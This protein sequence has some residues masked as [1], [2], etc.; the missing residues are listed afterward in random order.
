MSYAPLTKKPEAVTPNESGPTR[1]NHFTARASSWNP[2]TP[3]A[4]SLQVAKLAHAEPQAEASKK[5][6]TESS[7]SAVT[8]AEALTGQEDSGLEPK[9]PPAETARLGL[10]LAG[11]A[12]SPLQREAG[13]VSAR[14]KMGAPNRH[15]VELKVHRERLKVRDVSAISGRGKTGALEQHLAE[16]KAHRERLSA[17]GHTAGVEAPPPAS[18]AFERRGQAGGELSGPSARVA[19]RLPM[20]HPAR[21]FSPIL[22]HVQTKLR[23]GTVDDPLEREADAVA[24]R[25]LNGSGRETVSSGVATDAVQRL[26]SARPSA[27][28]E[29][30]SSALSG[31]ERL[32]QSGGAPLA[33]VIREFY[34][35]R[36]GH[37]F[38]G[39]RVHTGPEAAVAADQLG[40]KA[41]T[42]G[43]DMVFGEGQYQ[44]GTGEGKRLIAHELAHVVQQAKA[45]PVIQRDV[46]SSRPVR[47]SGEFVV[48]RIAFAL[49]DRLGGTAGQ[50]RIKQVQRGDLLK[51][52]REVPG[53]S[54]LAYYVVPMVDRTR[55]EQDA[56]GQRIVGVASS[57]WLT[58]DQGASTTTGV[59]SSAG[60]A[61]PARVAPERPPEIR[62]PARQAPTTETAKGPTYPAPAGPYN[63]PSGPPP[64]LPEPSEDD[65]IERAI[66]GVLHT[67]V[68]GTLTP[69][70]SG[71]TVGATTKVTPEV[72]LQMLN[73]ISKAEPAFKPELGK[74]GCSWFVSEGTPHVGIDAAKNVDIPAEIARPS[75]ALVFESAQLTQLHLEQLRQLD[76]ADLE[77]KFRQHQKI[78]PARALNSKQ[79]K[80][81]ERLARQLAESRMWDE[82]GR[83]VRESASKVGEV[84]L[85]NSEFSKQ[86]NG[87]FLVVAD[88]AK[89]QIKGGVGALAT[90][91]ENAGVKAEPA[92]TEAAELM[93]QRLKW[94]GRVKAVFRYGG[95]V[96]IVV[97]VA[98]DVY[99]IYRAQDRWKA[100]IE[101]VGGWAG[102]AAFS[103]IFAEAAAP[104]NGTG[105]WGWAAYGVGVLISGGI[106][107]WV[108]SESTKM[109]YELVLE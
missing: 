52:D 33:P 101:T 13:A 94:V 58:S 70:P 9:Y 69:T 61:V 106:G 102:A 39:V 65:K 62:A 5:R 97:A 53:T 100:T 85:N 32:R 43:R 37:D 78:D 84:I 73:N 54:G 107:Y 87:K 19:P 56:T 91:A 89:I 6:E 66:R 11:A 24:D 74:G 109:V 81:L 71:T 34:E 63:L 83:R 22:G 93:A 99:K 64:P 60:S 86:G 76:M 18:S 23:V 103:G 51:I 57:S 8:S 46:G 67:I 80:G 68:P 72:V 41:L 31:L 26:S 50:R 104:A 36:L 7:T 15:M 29:M 12:N 96:L 88:A 30:P 25:V 27:G 105:P 47:P 98:V 75:K 55:E 49:M 17:A 10:P 79:R 1:S 108:G 48:A 95:R 2:V 90:A 28:L 82:V 40:A 21:T 77:A 14:W 59:A 20:P 38:G 3:Q 44:P 42:V 45:A 35:G 4:H 92:L 16:L